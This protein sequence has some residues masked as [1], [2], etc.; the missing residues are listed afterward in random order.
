MHCYDVELIEHT[1]WNCVPMVFIE[2]KIVD[3]NHVEPFADNLVH[4]VNGRIAYITW[5]R[6]AWKLDEHE[7][8]VSCHCL[9]Q[10]GR[11]YTEHN[12]KSKS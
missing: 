3:A 7:D 10:A 2:T 11:A 1:I 8:G 6:S 9:S 4:L 12:Q 5:T